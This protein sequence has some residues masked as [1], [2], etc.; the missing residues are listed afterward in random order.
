M[1]G[2]LS[3]DRVPESYDSLLGKVIGWG[4]T[5]EEAAARL[6]GAL[7]RTYC[8]GV[9][10]NE[11]WL[12][13]ILKEPRFL[14]V[15]HS[16]AFLDEAAMQAL[17]PRA[18]SAAALGLAALVAAEKPSPALAGPW[19]LADAFTPNLPASVLLRLAWGGGGA[20]G[21]AAFTRPA[22]WSARVSTAG[23]SCP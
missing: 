13:R 15:R 14:E 4:A 23:P 8:A 7:E 18:P 2:S 22:G 6:A 16:I 17:A 10:T 11:H 1:P 12:A 5:R 21:T 19:D 3:G 9:H 20:L